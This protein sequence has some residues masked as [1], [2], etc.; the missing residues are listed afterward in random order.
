MP[1]NRRS[2]MQTVD[3]PPVRWGILGTARIA[4]KVAA[5]IQ[6]SNGAEL[7][8]IASRSRD[9]AADWAATWNIPR[10]FATYEELLRCDE[11]DAVYIPLP[12]SLH[13]EWSTRAAEVGK[14]VLCE[15]PLGGTLADAT[16]IV[17]A[18]ERANVQLMDGVMWRH[19]PRAQAMDDVL[20]AG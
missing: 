11:I 13:A 19:T 2:W 12:P 16:A 3:R 5:A 8:A 18:C 4:T 14:H 7:T 6:Q 1:P 9:K 15:K 10:S 17:N 20:R